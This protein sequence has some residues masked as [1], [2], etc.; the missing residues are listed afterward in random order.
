MNN[1]DTIIVGGGIIGC[2]IAY[3]L[4]KEGNR[5]LVIEKEEIGAGGSSRNGGGVRQSA[6]DPR[7]M[8][9]AM[10]AIQKH[11][12]TLSEEL[13]VDVEYCQQ[14]NLR[15][16]KTDAHIEFLTGLVNS[17]Q[18]CGLDVKM[19][20]GDEAR[21]IN[22]HL[23]Q[24]VIGA[25][26]CPTDGHA[27][28]M[29]ATLAF[30]KRALELGAE[31]II[32]EEIESVIIRKGKAVGV[33]SKDEAYYADKVLI[34]GGYGSRKI[35][36]TAGIQLPIHKVL[37]ETLVTEAQPFMFEQ[38]LGTAGADFYGHQT[39]HGSFV[40]GGSS[41]YE[42]YEYEKETTSLKSYTAPS[43]CRG[44]LGYFPELANINI[45]RNWGGFIEETSDK[46]AILGDVAEVPGLY[47]ACGFTGHGFGIAPGVGKVMSDV[48]LGK[49]PDVDIEALRYNRFVPR[50]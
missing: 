47:L 33:Q 13:G 2:A 28:P 15:L 9:L 20:S 34:A 18:A 36:A 19:I 27:N 49:N 32:G 38:M 43:I 4:Q 44:I 1:Y 3:N 30:Y 6:R 5:V 45:V 37:L 50:I 29:V 8:A 42:Q 39:K 41:G 16:G 48:I 17:G 10:Y 26:W 12:P 31:F 22:P 40:F 35:A 7:E 25:S 11:W 14:G 24:D 46:V 21:S 23:S